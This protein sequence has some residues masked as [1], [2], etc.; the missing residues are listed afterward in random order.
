MVQ[1]PAPVMWTVEPATLQLPLAA[2]L[3]TARPE[4]AVALTAKSGSPKVLPA[5]APNVI[6]WSALATDRLAVAVFPVPPLVEVTLPVVLVYWPE[7]APVIV[8]LNW[9]CE[10][11]AIVAPDSATPAGLVVVSVPPH[12]VAE[13]LATVSPVDNVSAKATPVSGS[14]F[15]AGFVMVKVNDVVAFSAI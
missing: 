15:A 3:V 2:K 5:R 1:E 6:V 8:T 11:T 12:T 10:L 4:D 7:A 9:H 13:E 14:T